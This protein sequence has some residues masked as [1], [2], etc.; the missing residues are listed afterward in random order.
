MS[1]PAPTT[2]VH[3][4]QNLW[5][6]AWGLLVLGVVGLLL[7]GGRESALAQDIEVPE[8]QQLPGATRVGTGVRLLEKGEPAAAISLLRST[9]TADSALVTASHGAAAY[10]L[11][12][13]Y[14][15]AGRSAKARSTWRQGLR[16]L[17]AEGQFDARLADAYL[18]TLTPQRLRGERLY[19]ANVYESLLRRVGPDTSAATQALFRRRVA[20]IA[21][22]M[23]DSLLARVIEQDRSAAPHTWTF[24]PRAG[25]TLGTWWRGLDPYPATD[26]NERLEEHM[27]RLVRAQQQYQCPERMSGLDD[28][29]LV[30]LRFG[31]P[32]KSRSLNYED[33]KFFREVYRFGVHI[34]PGSFPESE[35]WLYTHIHD[36]GFYLF[37]EADTSDCFVIAKA[38]DLLPD[39]LTRQRS[40][41]ERGLNIAY[42]ALMAMRAVYR[43]LALY[44]IN[45]SGR[46]SEIADYAGWQ[47]MQSMAATMADRLGTENAA[48][49]GQRSV[50]VG[51]G[52]GQT[53]RVFSDPSLGFGFPNHFVRRMVSRARREDRAA[54]ERRK[55]AMPRQHTTLLDDSP[56]LPVAVRTARFLEADGDTRTEVYW[57]VSAA[58]LPLSEDDSLNSSLLSVSAVQYGPHRDSS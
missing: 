37:A 31:R 3:A 40:S 39:Y 46:Y 33:G 9:L 50:T 56:Q 29:G 11:G 54:A 55:E 48:S 51:A 7:F 14:S 47:E 8:I 41:S 57:G 42:S 36:S 28:R 35:I 25:R 16:T 19:A 30:Q 4:Q 17:Q 6:R 38:N 10:W 45:F 27:T 32:F 18:R 52:V 44:H 15:K 12:K 1:R 58:E 43:E 24:H 22:L 5:G 20:Q 34:P 21:P 13:A 53:R 26:A 23:A 49:G 2:S